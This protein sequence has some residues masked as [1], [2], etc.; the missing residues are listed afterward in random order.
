VPRYKLSG[1]TDANLSDIYAFTFTEF[2]ERQADAYFEP[3]E[4]CLTRLAGNPQLG[5]EIGF[6]REN[7]RLFVHQRHSIYYRPEKSG[8]LV[9]RV[10]GP[11]MNRDAY[12]P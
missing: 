6:V 7:Y 8:I 3:L 1:A 10:L 4:E 9:V 11:G 2:G 12:L 5:R